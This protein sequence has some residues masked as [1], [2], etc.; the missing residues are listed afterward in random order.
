MLLPQ[1]LQKHNKDKFGFYYLYFL[2]W[3]NQMVYD[4]TEA[5]GKVTCFRARNNFQIV[6]QIPRI[7]LFIRKHKIQIIHCHLPWAG[8]VGRMVGSIVKIPVVYTEHNTWERYHKLTYFFN[9][10][11]FNVQR[12]VI[13]VSDEVKL[14]I[15][16]NLGK[17]KPAVEVIQNGINT[18]KF[19]P[20]FTFSISRKD[21]KIPDTSIVIGTVCVFRKQKRLITWLHIA[22]KLHTINPDVNFIIVGDGVLH[23]EVYTYIAENKMQS[24]VHMPGLQTDVR[25]YLKMMDVFMM[26]SEFE[27]L[28]IALLEAMSMECMPACTAAGGIGE[29]ISNN[30]NGILVP[31]EDPYLLV[32]KL[33]IMLSEPEK[34]CELGINARKKVIDNF[35]VEKMVF[36]IEN[37]YHEIL[38]N[39]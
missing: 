5:G 18:N 39:R 22:S 35:S 16:K 38:N 1:T 6:L 2:P 23:N 15:K 7:I 3:K 28:P 12:K 36:K 8:I 4:I 25:P 24:Y 30:K 33:G 11:T 26:T 10:T 9:K 37:V 32:E 20:L 31:V 17:S 14:S 21:F 34:I 27:G 29:L 19:N 13:A